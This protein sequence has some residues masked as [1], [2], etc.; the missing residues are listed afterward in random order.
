MSNFAS[1]NTPVITMSNV[2]FCPLCP[3]KIFKSQRGLRSHQTRIHNLKKN[4]PL[5]SPKTTDT[6]IACTLCPSKTYKNKR[7]LIYHEQRVHNTYNIP[8]AD[9]ATLPNNVIAEF[10]ETLV[11]M[12]QRKLSNNCMA[13]GSQCITLPCIESLFVGV[14]GKHIRCYAPT[15]RTYKCIFTGENAYDTLQH[16]F[17][18]GNW[19]IRHYKQGQ[20][21][22]VILVSS[23]QLPLSDTG[24]FSEKQNNFDNQICKR[25]RKKKLPKFELEIKWERRQLQDAADHKCGAGFLILRF[26]S[27]TAYF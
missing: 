18:D 7:G 27:D 12:I 24:S 26:T 11:Y 9:V 19:G 6:R 4:T 2:V 21:T 16:I 13:V 22:A 23:T 15:R 10:K 1:P 3:R 5:T 25:H 14:F 8:P 17:D 20:Q